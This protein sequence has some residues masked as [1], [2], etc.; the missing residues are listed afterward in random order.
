M[1][2][3]IYRKFTQQ[4][5]DLLKKKRAQKEARKVEIENKSLIELRRKY[6]VTS[7]DE[8]KLKNKISKFNTYIKRKEP[9]EIAK[10]INYWLTNS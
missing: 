7:N 1:K 6:L 10:V 2:K 8:V 3:K 9:E 4:E 5:I